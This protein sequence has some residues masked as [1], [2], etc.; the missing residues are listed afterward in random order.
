M[1]MVI[2]SMG[3]HRLKTVSFEWAFSG[4]IA[5]FFIAILSHVACR[6]CCPQPLCTPHKACARPDYFY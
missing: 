4:V 1:T 5:E 6:F 3:S 2:A